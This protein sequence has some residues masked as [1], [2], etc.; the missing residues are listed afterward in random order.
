M[1]ACA[2]IG[3][4]TFAVTVASGFGCRSASQ[5]PEQAS[6]PAA[7][8][9]SKA[10]QEAV[11]IKRVGEPVPPGPATTLS[12][13]L[14]SPADYENKTVTLEAKVRRNCTRKGC[15]MEVAEQLDPSVPGCRVTFKDYGFFVPLDSAGSTARVQGIV[16]VETVKA[17]E[18][19]HL[20]SEGAKFAAK[21]PDGT[22]R[23]VR[24]VASG[25]ELWKDRG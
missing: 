23:E 11:A 22:A 20:E 5:A 24:V 9:T 17:D 14:S 10:A 12:Q 16:Q 18:V 13:I 21:Q 1:R 7:P 15:W 4:F 25:V 19:V 6:P 2:G 3:L 8:A